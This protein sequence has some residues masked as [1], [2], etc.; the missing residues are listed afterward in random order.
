MRLMIVENGVA[1]DSVL[2]PDDWTRAE[3]EWQPPAGTEAVASETAHIGWLWDGTEWTNPHPTPAPTD[4]EWYERIDGRTRTEQS[5]PV[6]VTLSD[7]NAYTV[8]GSDIAQIHM[9]GGALAADRAQRAGAAI[10]RY[11]PTAQ[12]ILQVGA[13]DLLALFDA[14]E[15]R[16]DACNARR[17]ELWAKVVDGTITESDLETGWP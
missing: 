6:S 16:I 17:G 12:G 9:T 14:A 15:A 7:G 8:A 11:L 3:G 2:V 5:K 10:S 1:I 4:A 13:D